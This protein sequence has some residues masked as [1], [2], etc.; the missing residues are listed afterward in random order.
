V[1]ATPTQRF[2]S[3]VKKEECQHMESGSGGK[4]GD[5]GVCTVAGGSDDCGSSDGCGDNGGDDDVAQ[6]WW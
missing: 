1:G 6:W 4:S 2:F 3:P 5:D